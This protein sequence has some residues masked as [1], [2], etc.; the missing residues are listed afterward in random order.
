MFLSKKVKVISVTALSA[1]ALSTG[2]F[3]QIGV[4]GLTADEQSIVANATQ[5]YGLTAAEASNLAEDLRMAKLDPKLAEVVA[6]DVGIATLKAQN[7]GVPGDT[8]MLAKPVVA[9]A[10]PANS[11][12]DARAKV[13]AVDGG[14][15][16]VNATPA[17]APRSECNKG[18][19]GCKRTCWKFDPN[20]LCP[21]CKGP[22]IFSRSSCGTCNYKA[23]SVGYAVY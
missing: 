5:L 9:L 21:S 17:V 10:T 16:V 8:A 2:A 14:A 3:A 19:G 15:L 13:M 20:A 11:E 18:C 23:Q 12:R 1:L 6:D 7:G 22:A 4:G